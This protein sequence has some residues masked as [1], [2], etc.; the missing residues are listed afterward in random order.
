MVPLS[1]LHSHSHSHSH[2]L[3]LSARQFV[4]TARSPAG[5]YGL[6]FFLDGEWKTVLVDDRLPVSNAPRRPEL[7]FES[8]L[9]FSRCGSPQQ[10]MLW[11]SILEK[12][13]AKAH[14][15][16][17]AISGG[18]ISEA[19]LDL[20]GAPTLSVD[21]EDASFN[22]EL[23]WHSMVEWK[24]LELPMGCATDRNPE[25]REV[26]LCGGHAYSV[27]SVREVTLKDG[28]GGGGGG[29]GSGVGGSGGGRF[30]GGAR[31]ERLVHVRNPHGVGEW[32][33]DW[34]DRSAK[35]AQL[36]G[37][38]GGNGGL[39]RT[40]VDDG[41]LCVSRVS[42]LRQTLSR[43]LRRTSRLVP[44]CTI[45]PLLLPNRSR[46]AICLSALSSV[47]FDHLPLACSSSAAAGSTGLTF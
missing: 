41:T 17:R 23:L 9:A 12:A 38:D 11:A 10:Q 15:S 4:D 16:Y 44:L 25:L 29:G 14:G 19:L 30:G 28:G 5:C 31:T 47:S 1:S 43:A 24:R 32:N 8:K 37:L 40:G 20:T 18:E 6:R 27:L 45:R 3:A 33:G 22:S 35:W 42:L 26:G 7:A 36:M 39:E 21:F 13:Y 46:C 2:S 34:S